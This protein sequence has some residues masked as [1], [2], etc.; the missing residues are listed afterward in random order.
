MSVRYSRWARCFA[1]PTAQ[2]AADVRL[3]VFIV[4]RNRPFEKRPHEKDSSPRTVILIFEREIGRTRLKTKSAVHARVDSWQFSGKRRIRK[5][6]CRRSVGRYWIY[7]GRNGSQ[8]T[9]PRIPGFKIVIGSNAR[10]TFCDTRSAI[11][12]GEILFQRSA[13]ADSS[14]SV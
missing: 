11:A 14:I 10:R 3:N 4:R 1:R 8:F 5:R 2:A 7:F 13:G 12:L 9:G 6:T